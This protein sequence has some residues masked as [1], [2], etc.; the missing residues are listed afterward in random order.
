[1]I[2]HHTDEQFLRRF[3]DTLY[4]ITP[5]NIQKF[6]RSIS[7]RTRW[8]IAIS[9]ATLVLIVVALQLTQVAVKAI[10]KANLPPLMNRLSAPYTLAARATPSVL[11][12][13]SDLP[14][15]V[16]D[17][18]A[19]YE[20]YSPLLETAQA[21]A[22]QMAEAAYAAALNS[23]SAESTETLS[24]EMFMP[25]IDTIALKAQAMVEA[26]P[27]YFNVLPTINGTLRSHIFDQ[28]STHPAMAC[29]LVVDME[30]MPDCGL[31][32]TPVYTE[33][34]DYTFADDSVMRIAAWRYGDETDAFDAFA[35]WQ[36]YNGQVGRL[37]NYAVVAEQPASYFYSA[38]NGWQMFSWQHGAW[39]F[40]ITARSFAQVDE[41]SAAFPY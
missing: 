39:T 32:Y 35:E 3:F 40:A 5:E 27:Y 24:L 41:I 29:L 14:V 10:E 30:N 18:E 9:L 7:R 21:Q 31:S 16:V 1:M 23:Q 33:A 13:N 37:G 4:Q 28:L 22:Q 6:L 8:T 20:A 38:G 36:R 11:L 15:P 34:A 17:T 19:F 25:T 26:D 12:I 2:G